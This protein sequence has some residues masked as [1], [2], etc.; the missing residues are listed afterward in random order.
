MCL[1]LRARAFDNFFLRAATT[2]LK[3]QMASSEHFRKI[4]MAGSKHFDYFEL[5]RKFSPS[6]NF[7][8]IKRK[9]CF[10]TSNS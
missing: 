6:R 1:F 7:S 10:A 2:L 9:R 8:F 4:Q 3:L 5:L